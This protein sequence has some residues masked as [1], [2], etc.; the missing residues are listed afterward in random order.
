MKLCTFEARKKNLLH[1]SVRTRPST[2]N[3]VVRY[4]EP[5]NNINLILVIF[6]Q[7]WAKVGKTNNNSCRAVN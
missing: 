2:S 4:F 3:Q 5:I 1:H 6:N 7:Y